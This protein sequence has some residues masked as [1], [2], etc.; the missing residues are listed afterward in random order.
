MG[1]LRRWSK[2]GALAG[3]LA[4]LLPGGILA[5]T[6]VDG[7]TPSSTAGGRDAGLSVTEQQPA[8]STVVTASGPSTTIAV[9]APSSTVTSRATTTTATATPVRR[10]SAPA[11]P[12]TTSTLVPGA[13][14]PNP[15]PTTW[16]VDTNGISLRMRVEFAAPVGGR[17][18]VRF[19]VDISS[20]VEGCCLATLQFSDQGPNDVWPVAPGARCTS[21]SVKPTG[22][23]VARDF[24]NP[25]V[26]GVSLVA[27]TCPSRPTLVDGRYVVPPVLTAR[28]DACVRIGPDSGAS[29][30]STGGGRCA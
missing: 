5:A 12:A 3:A 4:I 24:T 16:S 9:P 7:P 15:A 19:I 2:T 10:A 20:A 26:Y 22:G 11:T 1:G 18:Q 21:S 29:S 28:I 13:P 14:M 17:Q 8:S 6:T 27:R 25:G 30:S 23:V